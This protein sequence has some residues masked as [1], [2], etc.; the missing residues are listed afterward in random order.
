M[1]MRMLP[2]AA[3]LPISEEQSRPD[4]RSPDAVAVLR[5]GEK[6][7]AVPIT[8]SMQVTSA[9]LPSLSPDESERYAS[10]GAITAAVS[11]LARAS[12]VSSCHRPVLNPEHLGCLRGRRR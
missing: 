7:P 1:G 6:I 2:H 4:L 9:Q 8:V 10:S 5:S 3:C 12:L 11:R